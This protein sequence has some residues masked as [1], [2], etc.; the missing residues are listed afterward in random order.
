[1][2][3]NSINT[4]RNSGLSAAQRTYGNICKMR[5]K[6]LMNTFLRQKDNHKNQY[7]ATVN[8]INFYDDAHSLS[9]NATWFTFYQSTTPLVWI[10]ENLGDS[11]IDF[12]EQD[13]VVREKVRQMIIIG[14][15]PSNEQII[16][17]L[18]QST[19]ITK[20]ST[21]KQAVRLAYHMAAPDMSI[22]YSP[23][24]GCEETATQKAAEYIK[25]VR[26]L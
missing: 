15:N 4:S 6:A 12:S 2:T 11:E 24:S 8:E 14:E 7:V 26:S 25:E 9:P 1:M 16:R 21:M 10:F 19:K 5:N 13:D 3:T 17:Q 18:E 22:I 20:A 23:A